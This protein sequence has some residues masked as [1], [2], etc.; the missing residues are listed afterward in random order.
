[1]SDEPQCVKLT[2]ESVLQQFYIRKTR[3]Q[4]INV[5]MCYDA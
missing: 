5:L 1:M 4:I 3:I 2:M